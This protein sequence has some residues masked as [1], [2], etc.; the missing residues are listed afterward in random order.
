MPLTLLAPALLS[1]AVPELFRQDVRLPALEALCATGTLSRVDQTPEQWLCAQLGAEFDG[2]PP[3]AALR[4][5]AEASLGAATTGYWMCA[6][7]IATTMGMDSVRIDQRIDNL[8]AVQAAALARSLSE[9]FAADGLYFAAPDPARWYVR[10]DAPQRIVTTPLWRALGGSM[11]A[12]LPVGNDALAWRARLN[13]AQMLLHAH[14]VN[15]E[16]ESAGLPPVGSLWWWGNGTTPAQGRAQF[17]VV[18]GGPRWVRG[19]CLANQIDWLRT[20]AAGVAG[21]ALVAA[22][23]RRMLCIFGDEWEDIA[24]DRSALVRW[25]ESWLGPLRSALASGMLD[26]TTSLFLPWNRG[27]L[28]ID[29]G[30]VREAGWRRWWSRLG[31]HG[32]RPSPPLAETLR[33]FA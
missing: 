18:D 12:Q 16:R 13:E 27:L 7:P 31:H 30:G 1:A 5:A 11:L 17:D 6:D 32:A 24:I 23:P 29:A 26:P 14:P 21:A 10:C 20:A 9:F 15:A 3:I 8:S 33:G 4:L 2:E 28:R 25:D 22:E 19:A